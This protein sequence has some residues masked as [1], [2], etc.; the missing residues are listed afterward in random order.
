M[1]KRRA[2]AAALPYSTYRHT[3]RATGI[4]TYLENGGTSSTPRPLPIMNRRGPLNFTTGRGRSF[5]LTKS[6]GSDSKMVT[7]F[8]TKEGNHK[9]GQPD[10]TTDSP[11]HDSAR[12]RS[13]GHSFQLVGTVARFPS[14]GSSPGL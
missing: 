1:I 2:K 8:W 7:F 9:A 12:Y 5:H 6:S 11:Q 3:F 13:Y 4:T 14:A 10:Q